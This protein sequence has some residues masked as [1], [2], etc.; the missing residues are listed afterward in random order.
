MTIRKK[1]LLPN[2]FKVKA[3]RIAGE[4]RKAM[5]LSKY[6]PLCAFKLAKHLGIPVR[7][8]HECGFPDDGEKYDDWSAALIYNKFNKPVIVHNK[9]HSLPRQQSDVMHEISHHHCEHPLSE[10]P[11]GF[12]VPAT[13]L[14]VNPLHEEEASWLGAT[15]QLPREAL[16]WAIYH[17]KMNMHQIA[18]LYVA[19]Q[20]MVRYRINVTGLSK[21]A[22]RLQIV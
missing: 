13:M 18:E 3:E 11:L 2:G 7:S 12:L 1:S 19:S 6:A 14:S 9:T 16:S 21:E 17:H 20:Q 4:M 15:L 8:I 10:H 5:G 22:K